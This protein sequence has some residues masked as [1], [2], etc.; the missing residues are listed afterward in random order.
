MIVYTIY[1]IVCKDENIKDCY[2]GSTKNFNKR[3]FKHNYNTKSINDKNYNLQVYN[4]IRNYG[5]W[6]NW[7]MKSLEEIECE[8]RIDAFEKEQYYIQS[9]E[10]KNMNTNRSYVS[11][12]KK[13]LEHK[14]KQ[15]IKHLNHKKKLLLDIQTKVKDK[16]L[17]HNTIL[18]LEEDIKEK[19]EKLKY[20]DDNINDFV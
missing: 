17:Y 1:E 20:V 3:K 12:K 18:K 5:G 13:L 6:E 19:E 15:F 8:S 11:K 16:T 14:R 10:T 2:I 4:F 9:R 7:E